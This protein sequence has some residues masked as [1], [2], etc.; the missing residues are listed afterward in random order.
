MTRALLVA[1]WCVVGCTVPDPANPIDRWSVDGF[2]V[3]ADAPAD[4][5]LGRWPRADLRIEPDGGMPFWGPPFWGDGHVTGNSPVL[6]VWP[7]FAD[8]QAVAFVITDIWANQP[9]PWV[10]PVYMSVVDYAVRPVITNA[11]SVFP[12]QPG[13]SFYSPYWRA[14][15]YVGSSN[16]PD[17]GFRTAQQVLN[18]PHEL[19]A[20]PLIYCPLVPDDVRL[21]Q[22]ANDELA[23]PFT[24]QRYSRVEIKQGWANANAVAYLN[25]DTGFDLAP[26]TGDVVVDS[27]MYL[28]TRSLD[29][30][31]HPLALPPVL[32]DDPVHHSLVRVVD[33]Q[34]PTTARIFVPSSKLDAV[35]TF[36]RPDGTQPWAGLPLRT[37]DLP[38]AAVRQYTL[39]VF[40]NE[41]CLEA[42]GGFPDTCDWLDHASRLEQLSSS[43]RHT[44][45]VTAAIGVLGV[46]P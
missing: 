42:D 12:I 26:S 5:V 40:M 31:E 17:G 24:A 25:F 30:L 14:Q 20:G 8:Q 41:H 37:I 13:A 7:A 19:S 2:Q 18:G 3:T 10:Q 4:E 29:E 43:F 39:R 45:E 11:A 21:H 22:P 6:T 35:S 46:A 27:S 36:T 9:R 44:S 32:A 28:F 15:Y 33:V 38:E 1:S 34:L 23:H 16:D